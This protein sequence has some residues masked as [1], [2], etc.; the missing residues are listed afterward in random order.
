[1]TP[2]LS[3]IAAALRGQVAGRQVL[4]PGP[5]HSHRDRSLSVR[6][7]EGSTDGF[8]VHSYAGDDWRVCRDHVASALG[9]P[10]DRW[11]ET[12]EPDPE[13]IRRRQEAR[14]RAEA[15]ERAEAART[16]RRAGQLWREAQSPMGTV[17]EAYLRSRTLDL[18]AEIAGPVLRFHPACPW[19]DSVAPAMLGLIRSVMDGEPVGIHRTALDSDGQKI[20]RKVY[21][22][23]TA[24]A[25]M[26]DDQAEVATGLTVGEGIE[27]CLAARQLGLRPVWSLISAGNIGALPVLAGIE[28][29]T[30]LAEV[31]TASTRPSATAC[32]RVG[33][34]WHGAGRAV[35]IVHPRVG[36]D[37]NDVLREGATGWR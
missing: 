24:A 34:R 9:L 22:S 35:D 33:T 2:T 5:G 21:G 26:L 25:I 10:A 28:A 36:K 32:E 20:G 7:S 15:A 11:R 13:E 4:A 1:M 37:M 31:D 19:G 17:V 30:V 8:V 6:P 18:P 14:R 12:R 29:L 3:E 23:A 16:R 27:T